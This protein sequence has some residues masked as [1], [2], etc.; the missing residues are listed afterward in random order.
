MYEVPR[1]TNDDWFWLYSSVMPRRRSSKP[2]YIVSNDLSRDHKIAFPD[3]STFARW[4]LTQC[5]YI[6]LYR[7][8]TLMS[9][10]VDSEMFIYEPGLS[11][12]MH[13]T[14]VLLIWDLGTFSRL[15]QKNMQPSDGAIRWHI[16]AVDRT[17]W[18]CAATDTS[19]PGMPDMPTH[20]VT[21]RNNSSSGNSTSSGGS[22]SGSYRGG[23]GGSSVLS[24]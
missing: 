2:C 11:R 10:S 8:D 22:S 1:G 7:D 14:S 12:L 5:T 4:R 19:P 13:V 16:P 9:N 6:D 18:L 24:F 20:L 23:G 17:S 15:M 3:S 21:T